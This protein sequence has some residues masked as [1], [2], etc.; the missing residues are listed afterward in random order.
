MRYPI[1]IHPDDRLRRKPEPISVITDE[2]VQLLEDM[3]ET[4][5]AHDGVGIAAPQIGKNLQVAIVEVDEEDRFELINPEIIE[6]SGESIDVEGCLSI[7]HT[8]GTVKRAEEITVR[9]FDREG[10]E[11]EVQAFGYLARAIQ[12]EIDHLNGILFIDKMIDKIPESELEQY[13]EE[14]EN[15]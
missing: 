5:V 14:H 9:Y 11:M 13:M 1:I 6:S 7:P 8:Y 15:D 2:L 4:M 3:Y 10:E 12:H